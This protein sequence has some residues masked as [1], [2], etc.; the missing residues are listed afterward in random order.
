MDEVTS[1]LRDARVAYARRNWTTA[2]AG[3]LAARTG[4]AELC[5]DDL[6]A[7]GDC[8]WWLGLGDESVAAYAEGFHLHQQDCRPRKAAMSAFGVAVTL[9]LRGEV[10]PASGWMARAQRLLADQPE[11]A[12]HGY[13]LFAELEGALE[14]AELAAVIEGSRQVQMMG[15]RHQ[16][17][18]LVALG[19][20]AEGRALV[21]DGQPRAGAALL[22]EAM[23]A[24]LSDQLAP[25]FTG[26]IYCHLVA[27]CWELTD[28]RRAREWTAA[29]E[30]WLSR[31]PAA[32][33][34]GGICRVHRA[35]LLQLQ[36][37]WAGA[38]RDARLACADLSEL[39]L[40]AAAEGWYALGDISRL[41][42]DLGTADES[43]TR[44]H[45][46][47][48]DPQPGRALL[49]LAH[50]RVDAAVAS[51]RSA[52]AA[53]TRGPLYRVRLFSAQVEIALAAGDLA[54]AADA[55]RAVQSTASTYPSPGLIAT[56]HQAR[57]SLL[58]AQTDA[59]AALPVL[60]SACGLWL[61]L[62][63]PYEVARTRLRLARAYGGLGD[64]DAAMVEL[65][66]AE[67]TF[68]RLGAV[69]DA[70]TVRR[71]RNRPLLPDGLTPREAEVL[72]LVATGQTNRQL[73]A[74]LVLSEKTVARHLTNIFAKLG[75]ASRSAATAYAFEHGLTQRP[76]RRSTQP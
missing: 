6:D 67:E 42:G 46:L 48:R 23:L 12:E 71:S 28:L 25:A 20:L 44:S 76:V 51:I 24:A 52:L 3:F 14:H 70:E 17:P 8:A 36:G 1:V 68:V 45:R 15:R 43:Y 63:A 30:R 7:L 64:D 27:A 34:F 32:V 22:D 38:E 66:A 18:T 50:G 56:A 10:T 26:S 60:R 62:A 49:H 16:D 74:A 40:A 54:T 4:T 55:D 75:L 59:A 2:R 11:S 19:V 73:A 13:L 72:A 61:E 41:R 65:D 58:L 9:F 47:G 35:Q 21:R 57:G 39:H 37:D 33:V 29:L 5:A 53:E 31:L 69:P